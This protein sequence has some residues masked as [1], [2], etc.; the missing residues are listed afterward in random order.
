MA[1]TAF[2]D[3][4]LLGLLPTCQP[5]VPLLADAGQF[6]S[7]LFVIIAFVS[8]LWSVINGNKGNVP[9]AAAGRAQP[10][11]G[12]KRVE[13]DLQAEIN[14]FLKNVMGQQADDDGDA[15]E[16][17]DEDEPKPRPR[18]KSKRAAEAPQRLATLRTTNE[19]DSTNQGPPPGGRIAQRKGPGSSNLGSGVRQHLAEHMQN[20]L[21]KQAQEHL[22]HGVADKV[23][24]D[25]GRFTGAEQQQRSGQ[26]PTIVA[27]QPS[28]T[29][30]G[31]AQMMKDPAG[32]KQAFV[33][34][35][36][37]NRPTFG[38]TRRVR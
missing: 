10:Q 16:V 15:L 38:G 30:A 5:I 25:L 36:I 8:W 32:L 35:L 22:G 14:R 2:A 12:G 27:A 20:R 37:L 17:I 34:N 29:A 26:A 31:V 11:P 6:L 9:P 4:T 33:L 7:V 24:H 1:I 19:E 3:Q 13:K 28:A 18:P 23:Q 21:T